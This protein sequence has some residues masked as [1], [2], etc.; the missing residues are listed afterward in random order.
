[1]FKFK[2]FSHCVLSRKQQ[3]IFNIF[4]QLI[5]LPQFFFFF[6]QLNVCRHQR[7]YKKIDLVIIYKNT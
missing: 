7:E 3:Y 2:K 1:M 4:L 6:N 5:V